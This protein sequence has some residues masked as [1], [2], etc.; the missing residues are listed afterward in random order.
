M[1]LQFQKDPM[2]QWLRKKTKLMDR[3]RNLNERDFYFDYG[4]KENMITKLHSKLGISRD[5]LR[6][7]LRAL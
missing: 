1:S 2:E 4:K 3:F 7:L 5:Q 6:D